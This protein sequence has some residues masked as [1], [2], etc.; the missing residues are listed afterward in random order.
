MK[1]AILSR[2]SNNYS[3]KALLAAAR[4]LGHKAVII[5]HAK[6]YVDVQ[7]NK[8]AIHYNSKLIESVDAVVPRIGHSVTSHGAA[9]VRQFEM[10]GVYTLT[11]SLAL[12]RSRDKLRSLQ[13][14]AR[15][16]VSIPKTAFAR[17]ATDAKDIIDMVGGAP[18][19]IKLLE[20]SMGKGVVLA[21]TSKAAKSVIEAF[22]GLKA[23]ILIQEYIEEA[24]GSDIRAFIIGNQ[25]VA[26][27]M[28]KGAEGDF[29]SNLHRGGKAVSVELTKKERNIAIKAAQTLGLQVA[30][31][32]IIRSQK[33]PLVLEVNSSPGLEG[34]EKI[35]KINIAAEMIK[36][37]VEAA[38]KRRK[39]RDKIGA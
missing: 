28:R 26:A 37:T 25:V 12:V 6:C 36:F 9:V 31:V 32:D 17:Q 15:A 34:I 29:R 27:M 3:S 24:G 7:R 33:G 35:S 18:V 4:K 13:L 2:E 30:G 16:G 14:I 38:A 5:N 23:D 22:Y 10:M 8:P 39:H 20:S 19:V 21:E 1:V 11:S